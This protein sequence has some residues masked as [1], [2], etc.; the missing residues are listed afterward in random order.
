MSR[1]R[2]QDDA[3]LAQV[4]PLVVRT[5]R[6]V[7][8]AGSAVAEDAAQEALLELHRSLPRLRDGGAAPAFA[9]RIATR[10]ALRVARREWRFRLLGLRVRESGEFSSNEQPAGLLE[11][12]EA[13]DRLPPRQRAVAVLRLYVGLTERET[14]AALG[15]SVGT[16]KHQLHD[17]R[18][19]LTNYLSPGSGVRRKDQR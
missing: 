16:V 13:F 10:V 7:V 4:Q 3:L 1:S 12:K 8:G 9:A 14:A 6:L 18:Q 2:E 17:A 19:T 11:L 15:C 5:V